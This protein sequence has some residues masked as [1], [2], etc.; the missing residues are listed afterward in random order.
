MP[1][2][3][4]ETTK[5]FTD[6]IQ[7]EAVPV[8]IQTMTNV[9]HGKIHTIPGRRIK[10]QV[11]QFEDFIAVTDALVLSPTGKE[12]FR[13]K[14]MALARDKIVWLTPESEIDRGFKEKA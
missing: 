6:L 12:M 13:C 7:K 9:I 10:D 11:N 8:V 3:G 14:F 1:I 5:Y 2:S 4:N